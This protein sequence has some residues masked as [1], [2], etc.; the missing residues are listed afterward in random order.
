MP[1]VGAVDASDTV[2]DSGVVPLV[3]V[4]VSQLFDDTA[5]AVTEVG[6][7]EVS[8]TVCELVV[9]PDCVLKVSDAGFAVRA[10]WAHAVSKQPSAKNA[11]SPIKQTNLF[12]FFT[13]CSTKRVS[14]TWVKWA[15]VTWLQQPAY[16]ARQ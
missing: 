3:G 15:R 12:V 2:N 8:K 7:G 11:S 5:V 4:T 14:L 13:R 1:D 16:H 6:A 9:T 10:L